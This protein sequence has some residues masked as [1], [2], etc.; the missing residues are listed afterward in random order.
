MIACYGETIQPETENRRNGSSPSVKPLA[1]A[2]F[3]CGQLLLES[4]PGLQL[5]TRMERRRVA[6]AGH[7]E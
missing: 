6:G 7:G 4:S 1:S 3:P 2:P 5:A